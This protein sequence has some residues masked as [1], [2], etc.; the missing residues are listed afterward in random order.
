M[1]M[2]FQYLRTIILLS[3]AFFFN[4]VWDIYFHS[5]KLSFYLMLE[6]YHNLLIFASGNFTYRIPLRTVNIQDIWNQLL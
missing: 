4:Q 5:S 3:Q 1:C 6:G 2:D